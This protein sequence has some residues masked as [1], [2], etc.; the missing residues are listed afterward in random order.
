M[1]KEYVNDEVFQNT[2]IAFRLLTGHTRSSSFQGSCCHMRHALCIMGLLC[3]LAIS[4]DNLSQLTNIEMAAHS[5]PKGKK[6]Y[7]WHSQL[8]VRLHT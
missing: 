1:G 5:G 4:S 8:C 2:L 6:R 7:S 3:S